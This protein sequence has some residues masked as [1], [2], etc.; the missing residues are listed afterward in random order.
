MQHLIRLLPP[1][2]YMAA[3]YLLSSI[4][5]DGTP[6]TIGEKL[7]QWATPEFQN[8]LH[9]PL[10]GGLAATWYWALRPTLKSTRSTG[11]AVFLI[12]SSYSFFD[13]WHQLHVPGRYGSLT[14]IALNLAG[15]GMILAYLSL[16]NPVG[17]K[18]KS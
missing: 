18:R 2:I 13:E 6:E 3:I 4:P 5:D 16:S 1:L 10:F 12:T 17:T 15:I 8:F 7:L 9:I 11:A 14:D